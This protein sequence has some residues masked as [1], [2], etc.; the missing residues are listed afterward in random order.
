MDK[1]RTRGDAERQRAAALRTEAVAARAQSDAAGQR[2]TAL[3]G[4]S[5][6]SRDSVAL[7]EGVE[8]DRCRSN[9]STAQREAHA[10]GRQRSLHDTEAKRV[11]A[12]A[13]TSDARALRYD[14]DD[15]R[16]RPTPR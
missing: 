14:A 7:H 16:R 12:Q 2:C 9:A 10:A 5:E 15:E 11:E 13:L 4:V 3:T 8:A 6:A 1:P